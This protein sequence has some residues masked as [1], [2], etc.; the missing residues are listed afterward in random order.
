MSSILNITNGDCAVAV[1]EK[2]SIPGEFLAWRD[3]LHEGPVPAGL[4]LEELSQ[5]RT[6]FIVD[7]GW[8]KPEDI[9]T[10]FIERD[11]VLKT[12][13]EY[14]KIILWF[15]HDLYD[16]LQ[17]LQVLDWFNENRPGETS[18]SIICVDQYLAKLSP[19]EMMALSKYEKPVAEDH[20]AL[21]SKA[22]SAFRSGTPEKWRDLLD[23]D[24][25]ALPF[26][27][28]AVIRMLEEYPGCTDGLSRI[29]RQALTIIQQGEKRP[30]KIFAG[31]Q[32]TEERRFLGDSSFWQVLGELLQ[33][34]PPLLHLSDG[35]E[36]SMPA[37][38]DRELRITAAGSDVLS[39]KHNWLET[40]VLDRWIGGVHLT[41]EN[42]WCWNPVSRSIVK[43]RLHGS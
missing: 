5:V 33:A 21:A 28:G 10:H 29:A 8:G 36:F 34:S 31:Y 27:E 9:A 1:M 17:L 26:L 38:A 42:S 43:N 23:C 13:A 41:P 18:I 39:G 2:A 11:S 6:G 25:T 30:G 32:Q 20:Y 16:Q 4:K 35:G 37:C 3:V 19:E 12:S 40:V 14:D 15:E 22:W 7:S 24:T